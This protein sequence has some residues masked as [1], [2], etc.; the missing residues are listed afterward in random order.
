MSAWTEARTWLTVPGAASRMS[1]HS[2]WMES[3]TVRSG[4]LSPSKVD[5]MVVVLVS[6]A[7]WSGA[8]D[9]PRRLARILICC[10]ASSPEK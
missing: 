2:V 1:V 8:S 6:E 7:S 5:R 4:G 3:I 10:E 9:T